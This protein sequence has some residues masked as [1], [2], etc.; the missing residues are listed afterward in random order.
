MMA[1]SDVQ[2]W[3]MMATDAERDMAINWPI[4]EV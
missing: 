1:F 4:D 2:R 3:E